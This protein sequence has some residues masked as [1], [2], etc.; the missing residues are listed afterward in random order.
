LQEKLKDLHRNSQIVVVYDNINFKDDKRHE[1][2]GH[3]RK[4]KAFTNAAVIL[5]RDIPAGGLT[6]DMHDP[7]IPLQLG[8]IVS[9]PAITGGDDIGRLTSI[10]LIADA[11]KRVHED[12]TGRVFGGGNREKYPQ[13]P[14]IDRLV[15]EKTVHYQLA[16]IAQDEGTIEGTYAVHDEI[17]LEQLQMRAADNPAEDDDFTKRLILIHGDQLTANRIRSTR[18]ERRRATRVYDRRRWAHPLPAWFH[19]QMNLLSTIVRTHWSA[20]AGLNSVHTLISDM[21]RWNRTFGTR[22]NA[23]Y[24][25]M[26]PVVTQGFTSRVT[27]LFYDAMRQRGLL[28]G[29]MPITGHKG[30]LV[31]AI[32]V[33][34]PEQFLELAEDVRGVAFTYGAW[35]S[36]GPDVTF[37]SQCRLLQEVELFL[38]LRHAVKY[39]D[40]GLLRRLV[41]PL[42]VI[43]F[44]AHQ[45]NY[46]REML[47]YR[48]NLSS[49]NTPALQRAILSSGLVNWHGRQSTFKPID[50]HLEHLN[51]SCK[52]N[53]RNQKNSTHDLDIEF[54]R[55]ALCSTYLSELRAKMEGTF[56]EYM[57]GA[58]TSN[59][60]KDDKFF[61]AWALFTDR[62]SVPRSQVDDTDR[63]FDSIDIR[64]EGMNSL[65]AAVDSFNAHNVYD[66][67]SFTIVL[68]APV[69]DDNSQSVDIGEYAELVHSGYDLVDNPTMDVWVG[70]HA[71]DIAMLEPT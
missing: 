39:G 18:Q 23:K 25:L 30:L 1:D 4:Y 55:T 64:Q 34:T 59:I 24:H 68:P 43:Y 47:Y 61:L 16:G 66:P 20:D 7:S 26:E 65:E 69:A 38:T 19:V 46:G 63:M 14:I 40:V 58:H 36:N 2:V 33:L 12:A 54:R 57:P 37:R 9:S 53:L 71:D 49:A 21:T 41:D 62:Y 5:N 44:G 50:L 52:I 35:S 15:P 11:I 60:A 27:A 10:V 67:S 70:I 32:G 42:I 22:D 28:A 17:F 31:D 48:W 8:E 3:T 51:C 6:R 56:G 29:N 13:F 45:T